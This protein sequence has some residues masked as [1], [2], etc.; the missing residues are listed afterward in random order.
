MGRPRNC[1]SL[2]VGERGHRVTVYERVPDGALW[3]RWWAPA[4]PAE[5]GRAERGRWRY[6]SLKH[7]DRTLAETTARTVAGQLLQSTLAAESGR[8]TIGEVFAVYSSDV[9]RYAKGDGPREAR[10]RMAVWSHVLGAEREVITID[11]PTLDRYVRDRRAGR[12]VVPRPGGE[13]GETYQ[14]KATPSNRAIAAD[15]VLLQAALNH[16]TKVVRPN[17]ARL[18]AANPVR[19]YELP[20]N[21]QVRRPVATWDR[22]RQVVRRADTV[23]PQRLFGGFLAL[24]EATGWR[25]SALCQLRACDVDRRKGPLTP[26]GAIFKRPETDKEGAGGWVPMSKDARAAVDR[27]LSRNPALGEWPLF[28]APR[29]RATTEKGAIPK[30]WSRHHARKLLE[31]AEAAAKLTPLAGS[32]FHA[33]RRKWATERKHLPTMDVMAAGAWRDARSLQTAYQHSDEETLLA[34]VTE[35]RKLRDAKGSGRRRSS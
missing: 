18:L 3:L 6:R 28:P 24:V 32:D 29:A 8:T 17:G 30:P 2:S 1:W 11:F 31:R 34:V 9:A 12:V 27:V 15:L 5:R 14:L 16:A 7:R 33:Y 4:T 20:T 25:V 10:R 13:P 26:H 35:P 23:D 21:A 19:G 22:F